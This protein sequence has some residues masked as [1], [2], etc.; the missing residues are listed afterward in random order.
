MKE[1][2]LRL[3]KEAD[4]DLLFLWANDE[5]VRK[6]SFSTRKIE[7]EEHLNWYNNLLKNANNRQYI[8][9]D[10]S[11]PIGQ[12]RITTKG[13][14]AEIGYSICKSQRSKGYGKKLLQLITKQAWK[15]FP[16]INKIIG[17]VK[18]DNIL[19]QRAFIAA[20][21]NEAYRTYEIDRHNYL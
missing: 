8:L 3:A 2:Y 21:Y 19:S 1:P 15:D 14:Y 7:Y 17:K 4:V 12:A 5:D 13:E 20:D 18:A 6:N 16:N 11:M 10:D 9:M